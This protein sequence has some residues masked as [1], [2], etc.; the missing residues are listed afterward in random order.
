M[1]VVGWLYSDLRVNTKEEK[2]FISWKRNELS[3]L[4]LKI[5]KKY[6]NPD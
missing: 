1:G 6:V 5:L 4:S 2:N 3:A